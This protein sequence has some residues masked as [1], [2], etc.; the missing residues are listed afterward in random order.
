[1]L[2]LSQV[3]ALQSYERGCGQPRP[4]QGRGN[5]LGACMGRLGTPGVAYIGRVWLTRSLLEKPTLE[6][7][8]VKSVFGAVRTREKGREGVATQPMPCVVGR[9]DVRI[10][11]IPHYIRVG[12]I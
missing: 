5:P 2:R 11:L 1:M 7:C 3:T 10:S 8:L 4:Y 6:V 12:H 9:Q